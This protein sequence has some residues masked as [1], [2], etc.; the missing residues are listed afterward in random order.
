METILSYRGRGV[1]AEDV[2]FIR[3]LIADNPGESRRKLSRMLCE[4]W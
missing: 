2:A 1:T 3:S 4:A